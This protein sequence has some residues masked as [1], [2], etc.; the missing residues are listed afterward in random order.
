MRPLSKSKLVSFRQC[1]KRLWLE[2]HRPDE[3]RDAPST[4]AVFK[5]GHEVGA[6]AQHLYDPASQGA[7]VDL[8]VLGVTGALAATRKLLSTRRPIFEAGFS[9]QGAL[10][11]ADVLL[12]CSDQAGTGWKMVEVKSST[13]VKSYQEEDVA[14]QSFVAIASG[15]NIDQVCLAHIDSNWVYPG[16]GDYHGL[17]REVD[18]TDAALSRHGE[19]RSWIA[20]AQAVA[21]QNQPPPVT[22]GDQCD[23]PFPCGFIEH[24]S[25]GIKAPE[26]P[27]QW[28]PRIQAKAL[29]QFIQ[30]GQITE[31][32][33]VPDELLT[34]K[35]R[36]V[37]EATLSGRVYFD[38]AGAAADLRQHPLPAYF[39]DFETIQFG[40]PRWKGTRPFQMIPFQ[41]SL[42]RLGQDGCL[43]HAGFL[44]LS[45]NDPSQAFASALVSMCAEPIPVFVYNA[46]FEGARIRELASRFPKLSAEL[47]AIGD[48]LVDLL[49]I[50]ESR[51]YAPTQQG[52]WSIKR[53]LPAMTGRDDYEQLEGVQDGTMAMDA[54]LEAVNPKTPL[55]RKDEVREQLE[56]YCELDTLAMIEVWRFL[57]QTFDGP[58]HSTTRPPP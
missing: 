46:G 57:H 24:C 5:T 42:H 4:Q 40:V 20:D 22:M 55:A 12:P 25:E 6:I 14:I 52:S 37:K 38:N 2:V 18:V 31:M 28:L 21:S 23:K 49:P 10:A 19:V 34:E 41:F 27:V 17:L 58:D 51:Y 47:L 44:D 54:F 11:F 36:R 53:V 1:P 48:R 50:A 8:K 13:S 30:D 16:E 33:D 45:G 3:R 32:R 26:F 29:K 15:V 56:R 43:A 9:A 39:L 7:S 35:Q